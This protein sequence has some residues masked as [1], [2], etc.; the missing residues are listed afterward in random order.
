MK[1]TCRGNYFKGGGTKR[2][3]KY[4]SKWSPSG[5]WVPWER[6]DIQFVNI[7]I[8]SWIARA[9]TDSSRWSEWHVAWTGKWRK[10]WRRSRQSFL[11][12]TYRWS[13]IP[14]ETQCSEES[15][16]IPW[17]PTD[18]QFINSDIFECMLVLKAKS[19]GGFKDLT[20][21]NSSLVT[22]QWP[23]E[24]H[25]IYLIMVLINLLVR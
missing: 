10:D 23:R 4:S 8:F 18:I 14:N 17:E 6:T 24:P 3:W 2:A 1:R 15:P 13:V 25:L 5:R 9:G 11:L 20:F 19:I 7:I 12:L 21:F 22:P 16:A